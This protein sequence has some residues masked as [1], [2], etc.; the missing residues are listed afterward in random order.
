MD[1][2]LLIAH[3]DSSKENSTTAVLRLIGSNSSG[4]G[5]TNIKQLKMCGNSTFT[6]PEH[7]MSISQ[8]AS[9]FYIQ[10]SGLAKRLNTIQLFPEDLAQLDTRL[11]DRLYF[12]MLCRGLVENPFLSV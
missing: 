11:R 3:I 9:A 8:T 4:I 12:A 10:R 5:M 1:K 6:Y 7:A 2:S